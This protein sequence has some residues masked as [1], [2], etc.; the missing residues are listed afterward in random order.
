MRCTRASCSWNRNLA[1]GGLFDLDLISRLA[2]ALWGSIV[3]LV[4]GGQPL[5]A[6]LAEDVVRRWQCGVLRDEEELGA[7]GVR[8]GVSHCQG[9]SRV[10]Q[11]GLA[12][13]LGYTVERE[14]VAELV[15][16]SAG[17]LAGR[18]AALQDAHLIGLH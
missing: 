8:A 10:G 18:V 15:A 6:D 12:L 9:A 17:A 13:A 16:R 2:V 7:V 11:R 14:F 4:Q 1:D 3:D 5:V